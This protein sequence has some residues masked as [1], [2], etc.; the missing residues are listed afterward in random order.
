M[1]YKYKYN[2]KELQD[3]LGLNMYDYGWR[4]YMPDIGRWGN[5]NPL[6]EISKKWSLDI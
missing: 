4:N 2:G 5:I 6:A 3:E 1:A